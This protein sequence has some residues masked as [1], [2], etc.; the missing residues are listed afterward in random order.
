PKGKGLGGYGQEKKPEGTFDVE[1]LAVGMIRFE[2]GLTIN[3]EVSWAL[4]QRKER[5]WCQI[6]GEDGGADWGN[7]PAIYKDLDGTSAVISP[8]L[9]NMDPWRGQTQHFIDSILNDTKPDADVT[10]GVQM[11]KML[12]GIYR[13]AETGREIVIK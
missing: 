2:G 1:D 9:A 4:H 7:E 6:F 10:Q 11:M 13:S 5:M 12:D 8:E 3:L